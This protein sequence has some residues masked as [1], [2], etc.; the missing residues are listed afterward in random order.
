MTPGVCA[1]A[2]GLALATLL[3]FLWSVRAG[4]FRDPDADAHRARLAQDVPLSKDERD[5][6]LS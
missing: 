1:V 6:L 2:L 4:L 5:I 3:A